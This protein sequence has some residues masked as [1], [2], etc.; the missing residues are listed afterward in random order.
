[1]YKRQAQD[2]L[3]RVVGVDIND[4]AC[5]LARARLLMHALQAAGCTDLSLAKD[6]HPQVFCADGLDQVERE[7]A[8][9]APTG[10]VRQMGLGE[11]LDMAP[12][13][14]PTTTRPMATLTLAETRD[15]LR[16]VLQA[17][18]HVVIANPPY[19]TESDDLRK[20]YHKQKVGGGQ[21]YVSATGKYSL[22][23]PFI[24]RCFQLAVPNGRV[25]L[26]VAN[27]F[28]KREFGKALVEQFLTHQR[29]T[30]VIDSS[31][32]YLP[33]HGTPTVLLFGE[34]GQP[35]R[36]VPIR[37]VMGKRGE[38]NVPTDPAKGQVWTSIALGHDRPGFES[39]FVSVADLDRG[40]LG[41]H[42]WSLQ[43]GGAAGVQAVVEGAGVTTL[44]TLADAVGVMAV[45]LEDEVFVL[46]NEVEALRH[47]FDS[48]VTRPFGIGENI[49]DFAGRY[50]VAFYPYDAAGKFDRHDFSVP[51]LWRYRTQL[52]S[53]IYF[54]RT[55]EQR[56]LDWRE[57]GVV[58][59]DKLRTPL[60]ITFAFVATHNHFVLDRGGKVFNRTAPVI[61]LPPDADEDAHL[62]LLGLLNAS[63]ACLWMK[64]VCF[65]KGGDTMGDGGRVTGAPW[66]E[67]YEHDSTKLLQFP[68]PT[69]ADPTIIAF[70]R[71]LD[72][73][74]AA[75]VAD[76]VAL[77]IDAAAA[78]GHA[79]LSAALA[80]RRERDLSRLRQMVALQ[81]ELDWYAYGLYGIVTD[82]PVLPLPADDDDDALAGPTLLPGQR[83]FEIVLARHDVALRE[84]IA[85]GED[86][87]E[88]PT[89]W[90]ARH[91]WEPVTD[92]GEI[93]DGG[94]NEVIAGTG[95]HTYHTIVQQRLDLISQSPSLAL[96]EQPTYKRRW[97][98]PDHQAQERAA[99]DM[100]LLDRLEAWA[101]GRDKP[102]T[103]G[104]AA[105]ALEAADVRAV[106]RLQ[107]G[108]DDIALTTELRRLVAE[109]A[110]P[111]CKAQVYKP[112]G[113]EKRAAWERTWALQ[114][115]QDR[116][117]TVDVPVPP[118]YAPT[119]F[120]K[121]AYW[122][123][124][125]K[126]DVPK[127]RFIAFAEMPVALAGGTGSAGGRAASA[128][129]ADAALY[130]WAGWTPL[131][132]AMVL[133]NLD[134]Q[135]Q[136]QG[137]AIGAR[138]GLLHGIQF[139]LPWVAWESA[140]AQAELRTILRQLLGEGGVSDGML[141]EWV[142]GRG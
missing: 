62:G 3:S 63:V 18:F 12:V 128:A 16:P 84:A 129:T 76:T 100:W 27:S 1:M 104:Q 85:R 32:A 99:L 48:R 66:E 35:D 130:G 56:G 61:K 14:V 53:R 44:E 31:G 19:I 72:A 80:A 108:R 51:Y 5:A 79:E 140:P 114:H 42:P 13:A 121:P 95:D 92:V 20:A 29:L 6:C 41:K 50:L 137:V 134:E 70:A 103:I 36:G 83:A 125:G 7:L 26:I 87:G 82:P 136:E 123:L 86:P 28:M 75:R 98:R 135:A 97:A 2:V 105:V 45:T 111:N 107:S 57:Y 21:R 64:Q 118:R 38:P 67:R 55:Q 91:G 37:T 52:K 17:G 34:R 139:L 25:A 65:P 15:R 46:G 33:G 112:S 110:V 59:K 127:E 77:A 142:G 49:R 138:Y 101:K 71:R 81:E 10:E 113:L 8:D 54:G 122:R 39:E 131:R 11:E 89:A 124:R 133:L 88:S 23:C 116:G 94:D 4:Y 69:P 109:A 47:G 115:A 43:G 119:D 40:T 22:V 24:E 141:A 120:I 96:L 90:F 93:G 68:I 126:L 30:K 74:A 73:L 117:E 9:A 132:R 78:Q 60:S 106:C 102:W 58:V